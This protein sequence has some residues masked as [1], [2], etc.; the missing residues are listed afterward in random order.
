MT[1][2]KWWLYR[3]LQVQRDCLWIL[4]SV[5]PVVAVC[6]WRAACFWVYY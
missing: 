1:A 2:Y 3:V 4:A 6:G 5:L